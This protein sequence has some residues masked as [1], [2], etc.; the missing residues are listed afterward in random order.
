MRAQTN[1]LFV[2]SER[3]DVRDA[4]PSDVDF[5][6]DLLVQG[7]WSK[8]FTLQIDNESELLNVAHNLQHSVLKHRIDGLDESCRSRV[9]VVAFPHQP[10]GFIWLMEKILAG[11]EQVLDIH[12]ISVLPVRRGMGFGRGLV[13]HALDFAAVQSPRLSVSASCLPASAVMAGMLERYGFERIG[14]S[15]SE[16]QFLLRPHATPEDAAKPV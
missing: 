13:R 11:G 3:P 5:V 10:V 4:I 14:D 16:T 7:V 12:A 15:P 6:L 2:Q 9:F 1:A 8:N